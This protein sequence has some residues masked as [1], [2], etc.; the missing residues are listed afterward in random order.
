MQLPS[1]SLLQSYTGTC[2][3]EPGASSNSISDQ[4]AQYVLFK[5]ECE[6]Q[7]KH[8]PK[9]DSVLVFDEVKVACQLMWNSRNNTLSGLAMTNKDLMSLT[10]VYQLLQAPKVVAQTSYIL[11]FLWRDLTSTYDIVG[12]YFTCADS[13]DSK[14]V[15]TCVLET[16]KLFQHHGLKTSLLVC[17]GCAANLTTIKAT[18][19]QH[20]AY[21]LQADSIDKF[22]IEPWF[23]NLFSLPDLSFWLVCPTYQVNN[24]VYF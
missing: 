14:F 2:L 5:A 10:D 9:S 21:S 13:V 8:L 1:R 19:G 22:E 3:H 23:I 6:K 11:Q 24:F 7:G 18:Q 17:D 20:G 4:V 15:L 16:I 12:P